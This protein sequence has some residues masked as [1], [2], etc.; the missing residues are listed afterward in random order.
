MKEV[1][2]THIG[3]AGVQMG[4]ACWELFCL[5][6]GV[7][8]NG[9]MSSEEDLEYDGFQTFFAET[10]DGKYCPRSVFF[11]L[12]PTVVDE[13]RT[14]PYKKLFHPDNLISGKEDTGNNYSDGYYYNGKKMLDP[15]LD[16]IRK[17]AEGCDALQGLILTHSLG[18][19]TGSGFG[20][21]L[22]RNLPIDFGK[23]SKHTFTVYPSPQLSTSTVEPYNAVLSTHSLIEYTDCTVAFDNEALYNICTKF[24][25]IE[26][27]SYKNLN[28]LIAQVMSSYTSS[29]RFDGALNYDLK[30]IEANIVPYP[31]IHFMLP[32]YAPI[33]PV[34]KLY[35]EQPSVHQITKSVFDPSLIMVNCKPQE[36]CYISCCLMYRG[37]V[38]K[39][40]VNLAI[41]EI[42]KRKS[43]RFMDWTPTAFKVG[44]NYQPPTV[45]PEG[46]LAK[47][48]RS[49]CMISNSTA[50]AEVFH[51]ISHNFDL[52]YAKRA[53]VHWFVGIGME[54]GEF[55]E[56]REDLAALEKDYEPVSGHYQEFSLD[57]EFY[58]EYY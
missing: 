53:F 56:A 31:R 26:K 16:R 54:S 21:L 6:H 55:C 36:C 35:H 39:F 57:N 28:R 13:I 52:M 38:A 24:L 32:S 3:Q 37:D 49:A 15:C 7:D 45:V 9:K 19:G 12:E 22:L 10:S 58:D 5:E 50:I 41:S 29:L 33:V 42:Q 11:D 47:V 43:I 14:G 34:E 40:D 48:M 4:S 30:D 27:P 25:D 51:R 8:N 2:T 44:I 23:K 17:L 46:D 18:G 20:S 1:M